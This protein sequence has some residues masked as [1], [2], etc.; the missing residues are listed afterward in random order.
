M[1]VLNENLFPRFSLK[2]KLFAQ[3]TFNTGVMA[4]AYGLYL[5]HA[6]LGIGY[7]L[8][9]YLGIFLLVRYTICPRC[10]HLLA[11]NDCVNLSASIM[12][13]IVAS[14]RKGALSTFEKGLFVVVLYGIFI[15]PIYWLSSNTSILIA[16]IIL[17]GGH[18]LSLRMHF[19]K[20]CMNKSCVQNRMK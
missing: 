11:A 17:Y 1:S 6:G 19:C 5:H 12:K 16:F 13:M 18:L 20:N 8:G 15:F 4:A 3:I 9:A 2:E 7:L 14:K 10:P